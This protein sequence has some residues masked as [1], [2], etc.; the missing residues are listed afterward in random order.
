MEWVTLSGR[1]HNEFRDFTY[2]I[3]LI[4]ITIMSDS[5]NKCTANIHPY[6]YD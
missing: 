3:H 2:F 6:I 1:L 4:M 5:L